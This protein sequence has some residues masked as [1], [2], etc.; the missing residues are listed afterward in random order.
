MLNQLKTI[1]KTLFCT[2]WCH[3]ITYAGLALAY[4]AGCASLIEKDT[5]AQIATALYV[6]MVAQ[7]H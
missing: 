1:L 4:G 7:R 5:V 6:T 3:R 2:L